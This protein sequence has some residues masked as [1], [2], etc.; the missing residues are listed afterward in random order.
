MRGVQLHRAHMHG[1][2][3]RD[4]P[5]SAGRTKNATALPML[6]VGS[7]G[8]SGLISTAIIDLETYSATTVRAAVGQMECV[9]VYME[10]HSSH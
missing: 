8:M 7:T 9:L 5:G 2:E 6:L 10:S 3:G 4:G 1:R